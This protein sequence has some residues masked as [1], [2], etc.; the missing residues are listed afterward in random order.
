MTSIKNNSIT[1]K[2]IKMI[3]N[4][5]KSLNSSIGLNLAK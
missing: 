5:I 2:M 4:N 3:K 1:I